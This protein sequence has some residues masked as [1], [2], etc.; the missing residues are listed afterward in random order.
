MQIFRLI[1]VLVALVVLI[2]F[3]SYIVFINA[4]DDGAHNVNLIPSCS[5]ISNLPD[6]SNQPFCQGTETINEQG[7]T[8][9]TKF[10]EQLQ[11]EVS[12]FPNNYLTVCSQ[13]CIGDVVKENCITNSTDSLLEYNDCIRALKPINCIGAANP[14]AISNGIK[15]YGLK[16][17]MGC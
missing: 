3:I 2:L 12:P 10:I 15:Y 4:S 13:L 5:E 16:A 1:I 17:S 8:I 7:L 11:L 6:I 9:G 14:V